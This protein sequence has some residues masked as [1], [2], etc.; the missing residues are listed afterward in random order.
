VENSK[1]E[2]LSGSGALVRELGKLQGYATLI[3]VL[4]GSGIFVVI[5][6]AGGMTGPSV[7]LSFLAL[8]PVIL[9]T[10]M[11]YMVFLSTP[12]GERPGGAYLHIQETF[13]KTYPA[14]IAVWFQWIAFMGALGVLSAVLWG[15]CH[16]LRQESKPRCR[17]MRNTALVL[18]GKFGRSQ[19][20]RKCSDGHVLRLARLHRHPGRARAVSRKNFK[21]QA[22]F[23]LWVKG[24]SGL[25]GAA[26]HV[27]CG[28]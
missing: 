13:G 10:A 24:F 19:V 8:Y 6:T 22:A 21:L 28:L 23:S 4:I 27:L 25:F 20:L 3:G 12:L 14:F 2:V 9:S 15:I 18:P 5:G 17:S 11:A 7:P 16:V 26:F 1:K